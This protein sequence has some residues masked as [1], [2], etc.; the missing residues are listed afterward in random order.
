MKKIKAVLFDMDGLMFDTERVAVR[1]WKQAGEELGLHLSEEFLLYSRGSRIDEARELFA[2]CCGSDEKYMAVR[3]RK[4]ELYTAWM[5][6]HEVPVKPGLYELL[7]WLKEYGYKMVLATST[8]RETA[9]G[10]LERTGIREYLDGYVCGD[11]I[12]RSKPDPQIFYLAAELVHCLPEECVVLED[13]F[14]GI[15]AALN[16]GFKAV[17]VPDLAGPT[18]EMEERLWAKCDSLDEVSGVLEGQQATYMQA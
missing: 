9:L 13:S 12:T 7:T 18:K 11:M 3:D 5:A 17:M 10:Y 14:N 4:Q 6:S 15:N 2:R 16:G 1:F 8:K